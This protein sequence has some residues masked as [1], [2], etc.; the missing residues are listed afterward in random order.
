KPSLRLANMA[1]LQ[2][3]RNGAM[4]ARSEQAASV[5]YLCNEGRLGVF[6]WA[7]PNVEALPSALREGFTRLIRDASATHSATSSIDTSCGR[8]EFRAERLQ[9][10]AGGD[11]DTV[12]TIH[13]WE[14]VDLTV[15]SRLLQSSL[16]LQE[17]RIVIAT[18][19]QMEH[20]EIADNLGVTVGTLKAYVNRLLQK[21]DVESR[22]EIVERLL[23]EKDTAT[24]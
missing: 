17:K 4:V 22:Q 12:V 14:P 11:A 7:S 13:H 15:A 3:D 24:F 19:Q 8:F 10:L 6:D 1:T 9:R 16:S 18:A 5:L 21:L 23:S 20:K 2:F